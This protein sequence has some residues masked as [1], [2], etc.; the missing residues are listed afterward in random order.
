MKQTEL[1]IGN[2][3]YYRGEKLS[4]VDN[5]GHHFCTINNY[6]GLEN[7]SD[8]L[9][10]YEPIPLTVKLLNEIFEWTNNVSWCN[11][12]DYSGISVESNDTLLA[13]Y[14]YGHFLRHIEYLHE[15]QNIWYD[16]KGEELKLN[17]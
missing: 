17:Q 9:R 11:N 1:R 4:I 8:D 16:L 7:G 2:L 10:D 14:W 6:N 5:I 13:V 3:I 15:L 12:K